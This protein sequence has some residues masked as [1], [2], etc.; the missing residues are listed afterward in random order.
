MYLGYEDYEAVVNV[1]GVVNVKMQ[2]D[3]QAL[4]ESVVIG[5]G[6]ARK[7]DLTGGVSVVDEDVLNMA[8]T[9]NLMDRL[10]GQVAG[11]TIT[12]SALSRILTLIS[13]RI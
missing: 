10:V 11:L 8:S 9:T 1:S 2:P 4:E 3:S 7:K 6:S 5:Y 12:T 13:S